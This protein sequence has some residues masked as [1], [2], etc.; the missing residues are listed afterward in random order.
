MIYCSRNN[1]CRILTGEQIRKGESE[2]VA[3]TAIAE[4]EL[5]LAI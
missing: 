2:A 5:L 1:R 4:F 3:T